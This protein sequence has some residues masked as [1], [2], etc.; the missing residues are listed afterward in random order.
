[1]VEPCTG[2]GDSAC[3]VP[4]ISAGLFLVD[5]GT[6]TEDLSFYRNQDVG[7]ILKQE[8]NTTPFPPHCG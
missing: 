4:D 1:M 3:L 7:L 5:C 2:H 6:C 8:G